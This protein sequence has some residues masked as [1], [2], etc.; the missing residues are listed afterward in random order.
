MN[1]F[2]EQFR[3]N[4]EQY[5][6]SYITNFDVFS[7]RSYYIKNIDFFRN[8]SP[9]R[10]KNY[11]DIENLETILEFEISQRNKQKDLRLYITKNYS[12]KNENLK[13]INLIQ[14]KKSK[15]KISKIFDENIENVIENQQF[16][17]IIG[18]ISLYDI[19]L[20]NKYACISYQ[21][22]EDYANKGII[23]NITKLLIDY[24]KSNK[25]YINLEQIL[26]FVPI[27]N[28]NSQKF[29]ERLGFKQFKIIE[30][31]AEVGG[32]T[33]DHFLFIKDLV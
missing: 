9:K 8:A 12:T 11:Y 18:D 4:F 20:E 28:Y 1:I 17:N 3:I 14:S 16:I 29:C 24:L 7:L 30:K 32:I 33:K 21:I 27:D 5:S 6:L 25:R 23:T 31:Y 13:D 19:N 26:A 15:S 2:E 10:D 22:D